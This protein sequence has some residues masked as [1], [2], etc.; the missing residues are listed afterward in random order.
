[1]RLV[2]QQNHPILWHLGLY[3][4]ISRCSTILWLE[5]APD[6]Q[7]MRYNLKDQLSQ[8][9]QLSLSAKRAR[10]K[11]NLIQTSL[12]NI[13]EW[14]VS[15]FSNKPGKMQLWMTPE[16][17]YL[18]SSHLMWPITMERKTSHSIHRLSLSQRSIKNSKVNLEAKRRIIDLQWTKWEMR[19]TART[20]S[21]IAFKV[22]A[23]AVSY[24]RLLKDRHKK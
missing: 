8:R 23:A 10:W 12:N 6:R 4:S 17:R 11:V 15:K 20:R 2:I 22:Y 13:L 18:V 1:M 24:T 16:I 19:I 9:S 7:V 21:S 5:I 3:R 14:S